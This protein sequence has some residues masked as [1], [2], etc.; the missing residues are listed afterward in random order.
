MDPVSEDELNNAIEPFREALRVSFEVKASPPSA[1][2][3][4][5]TT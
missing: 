4:R 1:S 5:A 3:R 2:T